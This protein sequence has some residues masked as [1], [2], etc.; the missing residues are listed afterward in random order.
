[1]QI[2]EKFLEKINSE[3]ENEIKIKQK[4]NNNKKKNDK[5]IE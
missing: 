2:I 4:L 5:K 3:N 1:M